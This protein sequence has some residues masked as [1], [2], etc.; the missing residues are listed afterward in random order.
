[1]ES[2]HTAHATCPRDVDFCLV[3]ANS[4]EKSIKQLRIYCNQYTDR[5]IR[6]CE[7]IYRSSLQEAWNL[8]MMLTPNRYVIFVSSDVVFLKCGW[9]ENLYDA[10]VYKGFEYTLLTNHAVFGLDKRVISKIGWFD[11]RFGIGPLFDCDYMIRASE[12]NIRFHFI[13][14]TGYYIHGDQDDAVLNIRRRREVFSD[15]LP[16]NDFINE[17][18]FKAKW[19]SNWPGEEETI[20][21]GGTNLQHS[22]TNINQVKRRQVEIDPHPFYTEKCK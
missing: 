9:Y 20:R 10:I 4:S 8:G 1:M 17:K 16:L 2:I 19:E 7:S 22:P 6:I 21:K 18:I 3:D 14:N 12:H 5:Q 15:R 11:E 13:P